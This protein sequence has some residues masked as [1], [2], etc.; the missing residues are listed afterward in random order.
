M[1]MAC[2]VP[3]QFPLLPSYGREKGIHMQ[4]S[5]PCGEGNP[6]QIAC[7]RPRLLRIRTREVVFH[8]FFNQENTKFLLNILNHLLAAPHLMGERGLDEVFDIAVQ[9]ITGRG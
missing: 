5:S 6:V 9:H 4:F 2:L 1:T 7:D 8:R 3:G